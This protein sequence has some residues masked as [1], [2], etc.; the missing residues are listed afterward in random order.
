MGVTTDDSGTVTNVTGTD[1][2]ILEGIVYYGGSAPVGKLVSYANVPGGSRTHFFGRLREHGFIEQVGEDTEGRGPPGA[3]YGLTD[4][5]Q[6]AIADTAETL[7]TEAD[8]SQM[9]ARI[10]ALESQVEDLQHKLEASERDT[11]ASLE[12]VR[13]FLDELFEEHP[14]AEQ[15]AIS[16][17]EDG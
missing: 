16:R 10:D 9:D 1:K 7:V 14:E 2:T 15:R 8:I 17:I 11:E 6:A 4:A 13:V 3:V 5:G 12:N